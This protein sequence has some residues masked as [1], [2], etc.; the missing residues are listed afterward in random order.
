M[1]NKIKAFFTSFVIADLDAIIGS[2]IKAQAKLEKFIDRESEK[3]ANETVAIVQLQKQ[4]VARNLVIDRA[5]RV[6]HKL[7]T[8]VA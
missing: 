3:L 5:Y 8:L 7:D 1:F 2:F 6:V 4:A